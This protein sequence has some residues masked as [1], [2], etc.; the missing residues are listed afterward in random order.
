[1][2]ETDPKKIETNLK[3]QAESLFGN[4]R[5]QEIHQELEVMAEQLAQLRNTPVELLDEP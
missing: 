1:M 5:A 4:N 2:L 3:Q